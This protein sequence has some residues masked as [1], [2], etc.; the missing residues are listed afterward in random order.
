MLNSFISSFEKINFLA[1]FF[2]PITI[3][4]GEKT[5][6]FE[7]FY[8]K[9]FGCF[10]LQ[11]IFSAKVQNNLRYNFERIDSDLIK[12]D[13]LLVTRMTKRRETRLKIF[14]RKQ[15]GISFTYS[16]EDQ[17]YRALFCAFT[18]LLV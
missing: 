12:L 13:F 14:P 18:G 2:Y 5:V 6:D 3:F 1:Q 8:V 9:F 17:F 4:C 16:N 7:V 11:F 10:G 15:I